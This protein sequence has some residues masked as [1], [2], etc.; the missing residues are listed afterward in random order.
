MRKLKSDKKVQKKNMLNFVKE[1]YN[2]NSD[3]IE[4]TIEKMVKQYLI[5][6]KIIDNIEYLIYII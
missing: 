4:K 2:Y 3:I 5:N 1:K 6:K